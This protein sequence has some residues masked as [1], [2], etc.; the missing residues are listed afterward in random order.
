MEAECVVCLQL[1]D[2]EDHTPRVL[3]CG[4]SVCQSCVAELRSHWGAGKADDDGG[5]SGAGRAVSG[6]VRCP[7]C[8]Q[9]TKIPLGGLLELPKNIELMRLVQGTPKPRILSG[10]R[11]LRGEELKKGDG[12]ATTPWPLSEF[13]YGEP[14]IWVLP[15]SAIEMKEG[16]VGGFR[17]GELA[18]ESVTLEF[19]AK[20]EEGLKYKERVRLGWD[21]L[22]LEVRGKL[23]R[24]IA[25]SCRCRYVAEVVGLWVSGEGV[26]F[27]VSKVWVEG[28]KQA[29]SLFCPGVDSDE[30]SEG[31]SC[32]SS[33]EDVVG[34][35]SVRTLIRLGLEL[36]EMVMEI[37]G[38]GVL[39]C[40]LGMDSFV[41]DRYG[42]L[43]LHV[44]SSVFWRRFVGD[45]FSCSKLKFISSVGV[46][47]VDLEEIDLA[48]NSSAQ[49]GGS[50]CEWLSP[51]VLEII[52]K[53][54]EED[55]TERD[56]SAGASSSC[57]GA[58]KAEK[59]GVTEKADVW[60]LGYV[61]LQLLSQREILE[62][63]KRLK[64]RVLNCMASVPTNRPRV[65][66]IWWE[67]K[68]LLEDQALGMPS[69]FVDDASKDIL[70][71]EIRE[72][73]RMMDRSPA[74]NFRIDP[75][76]ASEGRDDTLQDL[77][78]LTVDNTTDAASLSKALIDVEQCSGEAK[79]LR[80]HMDTVSCLSVCGNY[81]I[82]ASFD[83]TLRVWSLND[84]RLVQT[85]KGHEQRITAVAVHE[86]SE[87]CVSGDYA[88]YVYAWN[89]AS[90]DNS[91]PVATWQEHQ[92]WRYSGVASLAI[93]SDELLYSGSGDRTIKAWSTLGFK[94]VATMEG[95]KGVVSVL[96]VEGQ[97]LFSGSWDGT[98]RL[99]WRPD[100]SPLANFGGGAS[101]PMG[102]IRALVKCP[103]SGLIFSGHD[104]GVIQI[105]N[106]EEC[107]GT[108]KAHTGVVSA[109]AFDQDWLYSSSWDGFVK[110]WPL[111]DVLSGT[112][113]P[114][115]RKCSQ[116][117]VTALCC[118]AQDKLFVGV[119]Q[120]IQ[121]YGVH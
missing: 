47:V 75:E 105:W 84:Y 1:Y 86:A 44:G 40:V 106:E 89:I 118:S 8:K 76:T 95:H 14:V 99:W 103:A 30:R 5:G 21:S 17:I 18:K 64:E 66:D 61:L 27:L 20:V 68:D 112:S 72:S 19:L 15:E 115:E 39:V 113:N 98:I 29:R 43:R 120:E 46:G 54:D 93:S 109:L 80:G 51:E 70:S 69:Q 94:H 13:V 10:I 53:F 33:K 4:H 79:T 3:S 85:F 107:V 63:N 49:A 90:M 83:K 50:S 42:H 108:L 87:L 56:S 11:D 73:V 34:R 67:L 71:L 96:M 16:I 6:L 58:V 2:E 12:D 38:A 59:T 36:C 110:A 65:V 101:V 37:H 119:K 100:H 91:V 62:Q 114:V 35:V 117:A 77:Q 23:M 52:K 57:G 102:G 9:H 28:I 7:E 121:V 74:E 78:T 116:A 45:G 55:K 104:S 111:E 82:S 31:N 25:V 88:G 60:F 22:P 48:S 24:L 41:L 92:D 32:G 81:L 26:L 97:I